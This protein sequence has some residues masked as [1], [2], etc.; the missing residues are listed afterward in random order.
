[1]T[2]LPPNNIWWLY[3]AMP[4]PPPPDTNIWLYIIGGI[5]LILSGAGGQEMIKGILRRKPRGV[6]EI[7]N[8]IEL[9]KQLQAYAQQLEG[10]AAQARESAQKA[11]ATVDEAQQKLE[12]SYRRLDESTWKLEQAGRYLDAIMAKM[13]Q[14]GVDI[15]G[16]KEYVKALPPPPVISRNGT[17]PE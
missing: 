12:R 11:W 14:P 2:P 7:G 16:L 8:Q 17:R 9:A 5:F 10:D 4:T 1:M 15:D 3:T 13:F 6:V